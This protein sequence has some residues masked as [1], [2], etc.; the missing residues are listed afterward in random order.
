MGAAN[1]I[2]VAIVLG[3][4]V[5]YARKTKSILSIMV[6]LVCCLFYQNCGGP[7]AIMTN[8]QQDSSLQ[9]SSQGDS[10]QDN[11]SSD[12]GTATPTP[13][14]SPSASPAPATA[15]PAQTT[16]YWQLQGTINLNQ[17]VGVY[18][19]DVFDNDKAT[20]TSL[21]AKGRKVICYFSAGTYEDW[22][23]DANQFPTTALGNGLGWPGEKWLDIR[24]ATVRKIMVA[25][26]DMAKSKGCDGVEPD[27]VDG[28]ANS[29]GFKLTK[30]DQLDFLNYLADQV[31]ARGMTIALKNATDLVSSLV[32]KYDF[33]VVEECFKYNECDA[34]SPFIK[35]NKAVLNAEYSAYSDA[36]CAKAK[37]LK[38]STVF[39]NL[40]LNG[41]V[42]KPCL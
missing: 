42:F 35:A 19:L 10:S 26:L 12:N 41:K 24:D 11:N 39:F 16:W 14:P 32:A 5:K 25:R 17:N 9:S 37:S 31:H 20:F 7:E 29:N 27:N 13:S 38:F 30:A 28:Y 21:K 40:D 22:R 23:P 15:I 3:G 33:A 18:D 36:T 4:C 2:R 6:L 8:G 34:Y 1:I